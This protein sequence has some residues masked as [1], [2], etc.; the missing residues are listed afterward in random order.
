MLIM[1]IISY[2]HY[3]DNDSIEGVSYLLNLNL[4]HTPIK[5]TK[6]KPDLEKIYNKYIFGHYRSSLE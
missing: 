4:C 6:Y 3:Y 5:S 1:F 2:L